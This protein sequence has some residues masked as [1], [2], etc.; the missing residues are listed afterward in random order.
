MNPTYWCCPHHHHPHPCDTVYHQNHHCKKYVTLHEVLAAVTEVV[1]EAHNVEQAKE[2]A[3]PQH[4]LHLIDQDDDQH[5][6]EIFDQ[7]CY[8][9]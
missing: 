3:L 9:L 8:T 2:L 4:Y 5:G 1:W 7:L 6:D